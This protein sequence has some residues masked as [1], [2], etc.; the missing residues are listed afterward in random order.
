MSERRSSKRPRMLRE[1]ERARLLERGSED[2]YA[3]PLL[4]DLEYGEQRDD[5]DWYCE[6]ANQ[7]SAG[8]DIL[9]LGAGTGRISIP[10]AAA[11]HSLIALDRMAPMLE[12]LETKLARLEQAGE[13]IRGRIEALHA[14]MV[15]IPLDDA[16]FGLVLAPFNCLM[17]LYRWSE[18][19]ACFREVHR[20][21]EPGGTFALDVLLPDLEWL[22]WDPDQ[23]HAITP[24][25]HPRTGE[26]LIYSTNHSYDPDTQV[27]HIRIYYDENYKG[28]LRPRAKPLQVVH[29]AH[30]QIFPDELRA[31]L[32]VAGFE[33]E[34]HTGDFLG[35]SLNRDVEVQ[36]VV[37]RKPRTSP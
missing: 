24:F 28:G 33:L 10:I 12:H 9:E 4:Y 27:C 15:E 1:R 5:I 34:S 23:R 22:L 29:L 7:R 14:D 32:A 18:L 16:S 3:D 31:L 30:R 21:L 36:V 35:L 26:E 17:H 25:T 8:K 19:L 2:H 13:G 37:A 11:G 6:L 20:V